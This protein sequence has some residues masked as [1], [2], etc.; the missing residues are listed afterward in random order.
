[1][2]PALLALTL[3]AQAAPTGLVLG[4]GFAFGWSG[5]QAVLWTMPGLEP[6]WTWTLGVGVSDAE[7]WNG[8]VLALGE[9]RRRV[10]FFDPDNGQATAVRDLSWV[11]ALV[12]DPL[13]EAVLLVDYQGSVWKLR[14]LEARGD[15][16]LARLHPQEPDYREVLG[17]S[18]VEVHTLGPTTFVGASALGLCVADLATPGPRTVCG[19]GPEA[20]L[21]VGTVSPSR[22][23]TLERGAAGAQVTRWSLLHPYAPWPFPVGSLP[24]PEDCLA[25]IPVP[26]GVW[27]S[28]GG[29]LRELPL[30]P[31]VVLG[32][33]YPDARVLAGAPMSGSPTSGSMASS[34][35]LLL[36]QDET[37]SLTLRFAPAPAVTPGP[38]GPL[39]DGTRLFFDD[40]QG[41]GESLGPV[42]PQARALADRY[43]QDDLPLGLMESSSGSLPAWTAETVDAL[44]ELAGPWNPLHLAAARHYLERF[45]AHGPELDVQLALVSQQVERQRWGLLLGL[46]VGGTLAVWVTRRLTRRL[47]QRDEVLGAAYNPFRQDS[48]NNPERT[49]FAA[50]GLAD[51]LLR[52]LDLN[53]VVVEGPPFSGKSALLQHLAWRVEREGLGGRPARAVRLALYGVPET[54]FWTALGRAVAAQ[55]PGTPAAAEV[56]ELDTLDR[57]AV[58][59]LLDEVLGDEGPRLVLVLDDV[60]TLGSYQAEAQRFRGLM[61]VV[62]GQRL[63]VLGA[64]QS[65]RRGYLG[66]EDESPWF[67]LFQVRTLRELSAEELDTY[68]QSRLIPPFSYTAEAAARILERGGGSPLRTWHL[69]F[70]A[71]E[72]ILVNRRLDLQAADVDAVGEELV[73]SAEGGRGPSSLDATAQSAYERLLAQVAQAR[74]HR[75]TL[76]ARLTD[77]DRRRGDSLDSEFFAGFEGE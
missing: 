55:F 24:V 40:W 63:A 4:S 6:Q 75:D 50:A 70:S 46:G 22:L 21:A 23:L 59:Y 3:S 60:D 42:S 28:C 33:P 30:A 34:A 48:P 16:L 15:T 38:E 25:L 12:P 8:G 68:L 64:G 10:Y 44:L 71:V 31:G 36:V 69:C 43:R 5:E 18:A 11:Q 62:P 13:S 74:R 19:R 58:E 49:P 72:H 39:G 53:A 65:I 77:R 7:V 76:Q 67:N 54:G 32:S 9:D 37:G 27:L 35:L 20:V 73:R 17:T 56:L 45:P 2:I 41:W 61:Q 52:T 14:G 51:D 29:R 47:T 1:M 66:S 26:G 57:G